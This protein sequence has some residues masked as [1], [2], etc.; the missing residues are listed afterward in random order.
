MQHHGAPTRLLDF[1][2]SIYI[3][4]YFALEN[5]DPKADPDGSCAIWA[6]NGVW[7]MEQSMKRLRSENK[8]IYSRT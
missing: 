1:T 4:A 7:A 2:Y 6:V 3:A 8:E 5:A